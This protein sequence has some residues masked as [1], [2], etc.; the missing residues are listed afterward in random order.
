ML[1]L[2]R[3]PEQA[4]RAITKNHEKE[5]YSYVEV[6]NSR[7]KLP[8]GYKI[9][10]GAV[11]LGKGSDKFKR[12]CTALRSW[13]MFELPNV[14]LH[15]PSA[16]IASG[17]VVAVLIKHFGFWSL[18]FCRVVY[19]IDE[20]GPKRRFGFAY[21]TLIEHGEIG[22]ERF[23]IEWDPATDAV[24]YEILSFSRPA[25]WKTRIAN[26]FVRRLQNQFITDS[27][28]AM[29]DAVHQTNETPTNNS[30]S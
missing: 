23:M 7:G 17:V 11:E 19:V 15:W 12:A 30:K 8:A 27:L 10:R 26:P 13:K 28:A 16:P 14:W 6:G 25:D 4:I 3:P 24:A 2:T 5:N 21:G 29:V 1:F 18:N 20:D 22:E 9:L